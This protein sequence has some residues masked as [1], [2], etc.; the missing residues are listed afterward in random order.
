MI[1]MNS[2]IH[3]VV[4]SLHILCAGTVSA[5]S[6]VELRAAASQGGNYQ[7]PTREELRK[8]EE[9]FK[10]TLR[11]A[12]RLSSAKSQSRLLLCVGAY[13]HTPLLSLQKAWFKL[14]FELLSVREGDEDFLVLKEI[15]GYKTGR[16]FY[17]FRTGQ[18]T[19]IT[20]QA[21]H[22]SNDLYTGEIVLHLFQEDR[23][24][25]GAWN[26]VPRSKADLTHLSE[27]YFQ[28]FALAFA[29]IYPNGVVLQL[30]GFKQDK[31]KS[32]SGAEADM[33]ISGGTK[34]PA[35]WLLQTA[36]CLKRSIAG[37]VRLYPQDV[38]DLGAATNKNAQALR[39]IG[40]DGFMHVEMSAA[41]RMRMRD[42]QATRQ[43]FLKCLPEDRL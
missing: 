23:A 39:G 27:S 4:W 12:P 10:R 31:R 35:T 17:V 28:S 19:A 6:I 34:H 3:M 40:Y 29:Q 37:V 42:D 30:H 1:S 32:R 15:E 26:T 14:D 7:T 25:A 20:L 18:A 36:E 5:E 22:S 9:L 13:G 8:A 38:R 21:P 2:M 41:L 11:Q 24:V 33:I 43:A 16:G